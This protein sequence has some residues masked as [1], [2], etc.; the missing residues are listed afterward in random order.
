M[1]KIAKTISKIAQVVAVVA[2]VTGNPLVAA[3]AQSVSAISGAIAQATAKPPG[4]TPANGNVSNVLI[5]VSSI[6]YAMGRTHTGGIIRYDRGYGAELNKVKNPYRFM[7]NVLSTGPIDAIETI[8]ADF[9]NVTLTGTA[10]GGWYSGFLWV[11]KQ[12]GATPEAGALTP[13]Y[14]GAPGWT[15]AHKLSGKVALGYS[16]LFDKEGER[17]SSGIPALGAILRG[18][19]VYD[20][21]LDSTFLGGSGPCRANVESTY[22]YSTNPALHGLTYAL[23]RFQNGK[24]IIGPGLPVSSIVLSQWVAF[25][26]TCDLNAWEVGGVIY[27]PGNRWENIKDIVS[28]GGGQPLWNGA[29]LSVHFPTPRVALDAI[30]ADDLA[31]DAVN[32]IPWPEWREGA[33]GIIPKYRSEANQWQYV[34]S[35]IV[36]DAALLALDGEERNE[37]RQWNL[38]QNANQSAQLAAYWLFDRREAGSLVIT[39]KPNRLRFY[40]PG[41]ALTVNLPDEVGING[42]TMVILRRSFDPITLKLRLELI[43]ETPGKHT[44]ALAKTGT[45][46]PVVTLPT[47]QDR[48]GVTGGINQPT[49]L[50]TS[51]ISLSSV[52]SGILTATDAGATASIIIA[53]HERFYP[54]KTV[55]VTGATITGLAFATSYSV[56]YDDATRQGGA[57][58]IQVTTTAA[59]AFASAANPSRHNIGF[60]LTPADGAANTTGVTTLP[61]GWNYY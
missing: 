49:G 26:N 8:T 4:A 51:L 10:T 38:V 28:A 57:V 24:K 35:E 21:R 54:D 58:S 29:Q 30:N 46:P 20:P 15:T 18:N 37:E 5:G 12:L 42:D 34:Q 50:A 52:T 22:V 1:S 11:D 2:I 48:D 45:A 59:N 27:E 60:I 13:N 31:E 17:F 6:P 9:E 19:K 7:V 36:T 3:A 39:V 14:A 40:G 23:G 16:M 25:A 56:Y 43:G 33:N 32:L 44:V 55:D 61:P 53:T 47:P 41:D